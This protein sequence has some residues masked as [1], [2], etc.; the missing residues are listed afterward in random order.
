M[1][2]N[3]NQSQS[4]STRA[5]LKACLKTVAVGFLIFMT[6]AA[7]PLAK[8]QSS[9]TGAG[10]DQNWSTAGNWSSGV[11]PN[12]NTVTFQDGAFSVTTNVQGAVNNIV[13]SSTT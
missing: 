11:V 5:R 8:A 10:A 2:P 12:N 13:Q 3:P 7:V 1:S 4:M 6:C 9:W